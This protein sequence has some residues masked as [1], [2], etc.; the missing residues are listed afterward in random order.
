MRSVAAFSRPRIE[1]VGVLVQRHGHLRRA[2]RGRRRSAPR[3]GR[4]LVHLGEPALRGADCWLAASYCWSSCPSWPAGCLPAPAP[5]RWSARRRPRRRW[6]RRRRR[7]WSPWQGRSRGWRHGRNWVVLARCLGLSL[8]ATMLSRSV[9]PAGPVSR[10]LGITV[11]KER[12]HLYRFAKTSRNDY[13]FIPEYRPLPDVLPRACPQ[14]G[15]NAVSAGTNGPFIPKFKDFHPE[16]TGGFAPTVSPGTRSGR[17]VS[18]NRPTCGAAPV[19]PIAVDTGW[20]S[21]APGCLRS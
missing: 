8:L 12:V 15:R 11:V 21:D 5:G 10:G 9:L 13:G 18:H 19:R 3:A 2:G 7:R 4:L 14:W 17:P 1:V 20:P 6:C 16:R